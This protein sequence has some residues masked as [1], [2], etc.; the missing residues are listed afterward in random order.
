MSKSCLQVQ[1]LKVCY[2][3][4]MRHACEVWLH[5]FHCQFS[6]VRQYVRVC[7]CKY[8]SIHSCVKSEMQHLFRDL[9]A[10]CHLPLQVSPKQRVLFLQLQNPACQVNAAHKHV[11]KPMISLVNI[12]TSSTNTKMSSQFPETRDTSHFTFA[13]V[14]S[15]PLQECQHHNHTKTEPSLPHLHSPLKERGKTRIKDVMPGPPSQ[16]HGQKAEAP[17]QI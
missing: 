7:V 11:Q 14:F 15:Q 9:T 8:V 6:P 1:T 12:K 5:A 17:L 3:H 10:V 4:N 16:Q 13:S 2:T